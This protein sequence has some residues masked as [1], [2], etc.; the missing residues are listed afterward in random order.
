[1]KVASSY[2]QLESMTVGTWTSWCSQYR[3]FLW[4]N[5]VCHFLY[6]IRLLQ[7]MKA[8]NSKNFVK[9]CNAVLT[10]VYCHY[11]DHKNIQD[12][13]E[14]SIQGYP[15]E[16]GEACVTTV[17]IVLTV[18]VIGSFTPILYYTIFCTLETLSHT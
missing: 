4:C 2:S 9:P 10:C 15:K 8:W 3:K 11:T 1:M 13:K 12:W 5:I 7:F 17:V 6:Y 14:E 18:F 16:K